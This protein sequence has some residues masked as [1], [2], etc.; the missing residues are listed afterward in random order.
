[1]PAV[2]ET[3]RM[4]IPNRMFLKRD[5]IIQP[6]ERGLLDLV[7]S[8]RARK[9]D[10]IVITNASSK[11]L[12]LRRDGVTNI[13]RVGVLN[14]ADTNWGQTGVVVNIAGHNLIRLQHA[15]EN[16]GNNVAEYLL[17]VPGSPINTI[18]FTLAG[19]VSI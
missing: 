18:R 2:I 17:D 16:W 15:L 10:Q 19:N 6:N 3:Q 12:T 9:L 5:E 4:T 8:L 1:M 14:V 7:K 11:T 13:E